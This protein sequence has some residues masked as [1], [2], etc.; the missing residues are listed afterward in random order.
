MEFRDLVKW[1]RFVLS[2]N[3]V[4]LKSQK[5][6]KKWSFAIWRVICG[7]KTNGDLV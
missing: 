3:L 2:V 1:L 6:E 7:C 5:L 4:F